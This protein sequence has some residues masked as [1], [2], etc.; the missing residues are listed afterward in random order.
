MTQATRAELQNQGTSFTPSRGTWIRRG[1]RVGVVLL[2]GLAAIG[3][4]C[5]ASAQTL[6]D[7]LSFLL[8]NRSIPTDDFVR[9][10]EAAAATQQAIGSFLL[11]ELGNLP[12][13]ASA[14]GFTYRLDPTIGASVR[15]SDS[16]GPLFTER[17][18][19]TGNR[20]IS[21][22]IS[23]QQASFQEIDGRPLRDGL[24]VATASVVHGETQ[25]FDV[26]TLT[27]R[28]RSDTVTISAN[29]GITD[30]LDVGAALPLVRLTLSGQR[31]DN[32]R[33]SVSTQATASGRASGPGDL[34][35]R[36]KYNL[37]RRAAGGFSI[38]A[39]AR[40]PTGDEDNLLGTG[41]ATLMPRAIGSFETGRIGL[42]GNVGYAFG[43]LSD[44]LDYSAA[45][46]VTASPRLTLV[47][48]VAGRRLESI[49]RLVETTA[50]HPTLVDIDTVRLTSTSDST[51]RL[52][53]V[54]GVKWN[55]RSTWLLSANVLRPL[56]TAGLNTDWTP[57]VTIERSF[58]R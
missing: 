33:G 25:P 10:E 2:A 49:G 43:G 29:G 44:E 19:T 20:Q 6:N 57:T 36:S 11:T 23:Y 24:L 27:L 41:E 55:F 9:D 35:L 28:L 7:V 3:L 5:S 50:P 26:E 17:A 56:T 47:G 45:A 30:R 34:I 52:L 13:S 38:G 31:V 4:P 37:V 46:T 32:Y 42:H 16:F 1:R 15:S 51:Q 58:G 40:L 39:E 12:I 54:A 21:F 14:G 18:L 48:E 22:G 8:T 53:A